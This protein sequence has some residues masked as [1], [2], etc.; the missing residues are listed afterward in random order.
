LFCHFVERGV[1][2][3]FRQFFGPFLHSGG[4]DVKHAEEGKKFGHAG[5]IEKG[6]KLSSQ[7]YQGTLAN[8]EGLYEKHIL[9]GL[10]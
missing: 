9:L 2:E 5:V 10:N 6:L 3:I 4:V 1:D 8:R 7:F